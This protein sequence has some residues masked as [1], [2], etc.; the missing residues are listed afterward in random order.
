MIILCWHFWP[1]ENMP[2]G[3]GSPLRQNS[4]R[5]GLIN[6]PTPEWSVPDR[7][8]LL[9]LFSLPFTPAMLWFKKDCLAQYEQVMWNTEM[10]ELFSTSYVPVINI[11]ILNRRFKSFHPENCGWTELVWCQFLSQGKEG[12]QHFFVVWIIWLHPMAG[13]EKSV[14]GQ[15]MQFW[16]NFVQEY[17]LL[18]PIVEDEPWPMQRLEGK[19]FWAPKGTTSPWVRRVF[20]GML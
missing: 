20:E 18:L 6:Y 7:R 10:K 4:F 1:T 11:P 14:L 3:E 9:S 19:I 15:D 17:H 8:M 2:G 12:Q 16:Y 13:K 5:Q